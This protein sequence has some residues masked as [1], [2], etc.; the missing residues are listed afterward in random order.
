MVMLKVI[1]VQLSAL[2]HDYEVLN[3]SVS[4]AWSVAN[5]TITISLKGQ[6][7]QKVA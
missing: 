2:F 3:M 7:T 4:K 1:N 5:N 6:E